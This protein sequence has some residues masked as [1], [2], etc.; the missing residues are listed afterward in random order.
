MSTSAQAGP[1]IGEQPDQYLL[2]GHDSELDRLQLQSR[3][4]EPSGRRLL[5]E[6]GE[7][8]GARVVDVGCGALGWLRLL[9]AWVGP[10]GEV[11]GTDTDE[12]ML[13]AAERFVA[14]EELANVVLVKDDLFAS[15]LEPASFDLVH[16]RFQL[17]PLG[18]GPEQ[19]AAHLRLVGPGGAVVLEELDPY[20]WH[21]IP[22][23]PALGIDYT[24][25]LGTQLIPLIGEAFRKAGGDS[26]AAA[27]QLE[28]LR[29]SGIEPKVRA[30]VLALPPGHPYL[31]LP[32][33]LSSALQG[34]LQSIVG[35][36]ELERL[37]QEAERELQ[38]PGR[39]GITFTL[40]QAWGRREAQVG[41]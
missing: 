7:G 8:R 19:M 13:A 29:T 34:L 4:W 33:Q 1:Q 20:S 35:A 41:A 30:E 10:D 15:D 21:F 16:A 32:L 27:T 14:A 3:V 37:E 31:R 40:L 2:G 17:A 24:R 39:W 5:E 11:V 12:A 26:D 36:D 9:S 18:R 38:N 22:A 25:P 28:L 6:I 23:A